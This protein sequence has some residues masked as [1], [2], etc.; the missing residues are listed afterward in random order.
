MAAHALAPRPDVAQLNPAELVFVAQH[1][2]LVSGL[3]GGTVTPDALGALYDRVL[4]TWVATPEPDRA[5]AQQLVRAFAIALGDLVVERVPGVA[6]VSSTDA[7]GTELALAHPDSDV[8]V[9]PRAVVARRW[10]EGET[11][12]LA[13]YPDE[14]ATGLTQLLTAAH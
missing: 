14:I 9:Y 13:G 1:R 10:S 8:L 6:W 11:G 2:E 5:D 7:E 3:C 4:V 12:W